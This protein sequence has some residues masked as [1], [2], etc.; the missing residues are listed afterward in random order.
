MASVSVRYI[1]DD[2]DAAIAFYCLHLGFTE[3]MHPAPM[4]AILSRGDLRLLL[5]SPVRGGPG[6]GSSAMPDGTMPE[7]GG[8]NRISLEVTDLE[9]IVDSL[10]SA[11]SR[12]ATTS[13]PG[14]AAGRS[15]SMIRPAIRSSCSSP[16]AKPS[17]S[18]RQALRF[19]IMGI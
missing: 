12:S 18:R 2:V 8:W 11:G 15:C 1:V 13:S 5:S 6:G 17:P 10:R 19:M 4:F 16:T 7:P 14:S 3:E 9:E